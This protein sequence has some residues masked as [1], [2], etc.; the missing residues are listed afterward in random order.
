MTDADGVIINGDIDG[1]LAAD[2]TISGNDASRVFMIS[3]AGNSAELRSLD[4]TNGFTAEARGGAIFSGADT[5]MTLVNSTVRDSASYLAAGG[6]TIY[7]TAN[8]VN[9]TFTGNAS[10]YVTAL[11][12]SG[13]DGVG[14]LFNVTV[15]GNTETGGLG[16]N[17]VGAIAGQLTI[18]N[19]TLQGDAAVFGGSTVNIYNSAVDGTVLGALASA[20]NSVFKD[21]P[22]I[23]NGAGNLTNVAD[24]GLG[25]LADN[26]GP[27]QTLAP[28]IGSV[29]INAGDVAYLPL[30]TGDADG[31]GDRAETL[32]IAADGGVRLLGSGLEAG[33]VEFT[34]PDAIDDA[35]STDEATAIGVGLNLFDANGTTADSSVDGNLTITAVNG[36]AADVGMQVTLASGALCLS[37][38]TARSLM[39]RTVHSKP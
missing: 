5:N 27:V 37:M 18:T 12:V 29:L 25:A 15:T 14:T 2:I 33:A 26:G 34:L 32:S 38:T 20:Y 28:Q 22:S 35:F 17:G 8:V 23:T 11:E 30:D 13:T 9:S 36:E 7:G 6:M 4:I 31:D 16:M 39:I 3:G 19:S 1:D 24:L 10:Q 21:A